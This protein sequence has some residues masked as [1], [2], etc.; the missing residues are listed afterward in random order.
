MLCIYYV[1]MNIV[2]KTIYCYKSSDS[3]R[4]VGERV[5]GGIGGVSG[6]SAPLVILLLLDICVLSI[7]IDTIAIM[8]C[9]LTLILNKL[10][11]YGMVAIRC[12]WAGWL[13]DG[14]DGWLAT[15]LGW[16]ATWLPG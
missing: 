15:W 3:F 16:L 10:L 4:R 13:S 5:P 11:I 7:P 8:Q 6:V 14:L 12:Y 9:L 2:P 1:F